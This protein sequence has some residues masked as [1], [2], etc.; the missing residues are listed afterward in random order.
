METIIEK[1]ILELEFEN[2]ELT[3]GTLILI[4]K[5]VISELKAILKCK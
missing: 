2:L 3:N 1:R 5:T 4:N